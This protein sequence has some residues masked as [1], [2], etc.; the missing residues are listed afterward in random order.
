MASKAEALKDPYI[1]IVYAAR[2]GEGVRL[3]ADEVHT[4]GRMDDAIQTYAMNRAE[5]I[6]LT[7]D[8][9]IEMGL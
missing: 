5:E 4:M 9:M 7:V 8:Q 2:R 3:S 6:G 1:R